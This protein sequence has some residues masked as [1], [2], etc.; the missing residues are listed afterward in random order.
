MS[1]PSLA[2]EG[3]G[4]AVLQLLLQALCGEATLGQLGLELRHLHA[5][6]VDWLAIARPGSSD[7][8][9]RRLARGGGGDGGMMCC[10]GGSSGCGRSSSSGGGRLGLAMVLVW[11][12]GGMCCRAG[13]RGRG[14]FGRSWSCSGSRCC[15]VVDLHG[16]AWGLGS[17]SC[18][19]RL[20]GVV[21]LSFGLHRRR[22]LT[23]LLLLCGL[24]Q[25]RGRVRG[26]CHQWLLLVGVH[27]VQALAANV[28]HELG[29]LGHAWHD[30]RGR[31]SLVHRPLD[32]AIGLARVELEC[33]GPHQQLLEHGL[34]LEARLKQRL[35]AKDVEAQARAG[36]GDDEAADVADV[37]DVRCAD[38]GE[39]D[40]VVLRALVLV[41]RLDL[42]REAE[43]RVAA[44]AGLH[45]VAQQ[46]LLAV[47]CGQQGDA[48]GR[49]AEQAH[50]HVGRHHVLG[51]AQ[52]LEEVGLRAV[53][54]AAVEVGHVDKLEVVAEASV[55]DRELG[56]GEGV[57]QVAELLVA[58]GEE[59]GQ[60][61]P[62]AALGIEIDRGHAQANEAVEHA[63]LQVG[64]GLQRQVLDH[65]RQLVVVADEDDA[66]QAVLRD[67]LL[68][69]HGDKRLNVQHLRS[70]LH[71]D[72]VV[73]EAQLGQLLV[74][75]R[76]MRAG[77]GNDLGL[78][79]QQIARPVL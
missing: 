47:V 9:R 29:Q 45:N 18:V 38:E 2:L 16:L 53:L 19:I 65:G 57:A 68:Q 73:L 46:S 66:L 64:E 30:Q 71:Q 20:V 44:A 50:V 78:L 15:C 23:L 51:L 61:R 24:A 60:R 62:A 12:C 31:A 79:H 55:G 28:E 3:L 43:E 27:C 13:R 11:C 26:R 56:Q 21:S 37:A 74:R 42:G 72:V 58:P 63:L 59:R 49:V 4:E 10:G 25:G 77:H 76:S 75:E 6:R 1:L 40:V 54:A 33:C 5:L 70:L 41:D 17:H 67:G 7:S 48:L 39:E 52:V 34:Q 22:L 14:G 36:D 35:P 32:H 69:G 8:R